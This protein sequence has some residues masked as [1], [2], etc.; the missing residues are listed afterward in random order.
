[1]KLLRRWFVILAL[2]Y[3]GIC[4]VMYCLQ[5]RLLFP[6]PQDD[7]FT[8]A[9][10]RHWQLIHLQVAPGV[11]LEGWL[12]RAPAPGAPL[13]L[14]FGGNAD[15]AAYALPDL[16]WQGWS[17]LSVNY[18]GFGQSQGEPGEAALV[19]DAIA[20]YDWAHATLHPAAVYVLGRSL[21]TGVA[22]QLAAQRPVRR[23]A[24]ITP[25]DSVL[26]VAEEQYPWL[27][28]P[29][30][31]K[32]RF[33]SVAL[34]PQLRIPALFLVAEHDTLIP[35]PH[36]RVLYA[37]WAGPKQWREYAGTTHIDIVG[38]PVL[39]Q[40]VRRFFEGPEHQE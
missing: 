24:L 11:R 31:L 15:D 6:R 12:M 35:Q 14:Q 40:A 17:V 28:V 32:H 1:M 19:H 22:V 20:E 37:A 29:L 9:P 21:G 7:G 30:L 23:L 16:D 5:E 4:V 13:L 34:A 26:A 38:Q 36:A 2:L 33:D 18:R 8:A 39:W 10:G 3:I 27:P 25:Y